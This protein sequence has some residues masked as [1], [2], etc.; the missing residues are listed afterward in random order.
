MEQD[1]FGWLNSTH[2][3]SPQ[4][5]G[6]GLLLAPLS[7]TQPPETEALQEIPTPHDEPEPLA[8]EELQELQDEV[9]ELQAEIEDE[10]QEP[11]EP[12]SLPEYEPADYLPE[13]P[14]HAAV[15]DETQEPEEPSSLPEYEP[16]DDLPDEIPD[17]HEWQEQATGFTLSLDEPPPELWTNLNNDDDE[18]LDYEP[19]DSLQGAAYVQIHGR[20]FTE[21]LHHTLK[22]RK[23]RAQERAESERENPSRGYIQ[24]AVIL[25]ATMLMAL[26]L[27]WPALWLLNRETP[28]GMKARAEALVEAGKFEE[29]AGIY[30]KAH[31]RYPG[32][33]MFLKGLAET[34]EKAGLTQ[35]A[36][37]AQEEYL[38]AIASDDEPP[39][40]KHDDEEEPMPEP[41]T[42]LLPPR[43]PEQPNPKEIPKPLTFEEYINE[44]NRNYNIGMYSR[45]VVNFFRAMELNSRDIRPYI[46]LSGA[47]R[48][49]GMFFD[50]KRILDEARKRF[51]RNPTIEMGYKFL[52]EAK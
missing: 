14:G 26:G 18:E 31:R 6:T 11:E 22:H 43:K 20:N 39:L 29:A 13:I 33:I 5:Q 47:Y 38:K 35:T 40:Q 19:T 25:C 45:A 37:T 16:T 21:R 28:E 23:E 42:I 32:D 27:S 2:S 8:V 7:D 4:S 10:T 49:R 50:S 34:S 44:G 12:S 24:K 30:R 41:V 9:R 1:L 3:N 36:R 15:D 46:G 48:E 51:Q 17:D 52:R